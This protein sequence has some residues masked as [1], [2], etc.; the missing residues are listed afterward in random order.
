MNAEGEE[1]ILEGTAALGEDS[2]SALLEELGD[3]TPGETARV[4][5]QAR[6][7]RTSSRLPA[8]ISEAEVDLRLAVITEP[9]GCYRGD[10]AFG[11]RVV[12]SAAAVLAMQ[13]VGPEIAPV[14]G[15]P[16]RIVGGLELRHLA[17]PVL[18]ERDYLV[19]GRVLA[20]SATARDET[21]WYQADL[22][23]AESGAPV[24]CMIHM[25]RFSQGILPLSHLVQH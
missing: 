12:P 21:V 8:R 2:S 18:C 22:C 11:G 3:A 16:Q 14:E 19:Q 7:G 25:E 23:E 5:V 4:L 10:A 20:V 15:K 6:P 9:M 1:L 17:G 24:A 13:A